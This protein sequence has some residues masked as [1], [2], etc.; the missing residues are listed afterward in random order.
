MTISRHSHTAQEIGMYALGIIVHI[1][2]ANTFQ[3]LV[4]HHMQSLS[5]MIMPQ[6]Y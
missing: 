5:A 2:V 3:L 6:V 4:L 1:H